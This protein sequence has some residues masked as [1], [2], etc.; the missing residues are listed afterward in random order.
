V[1]TLQAATEAVAT[2]GAVRI[3][4]LGELQVRRAGR[5]VALPASKRTRA[6]LGYLVASGGA[7]SRHALCDLLWDGPDDPRAELRWC[8]SKLRPVLDEPA[9]TRIVADRERVAFV[10][11]GA[12]TDLGELG[13]LL[14]AGLPAAPVPVLENAATLLAGEFLDG[15]ELPTCYRYN[16]WCMAERERHGALRV[17]VVAALV[18][19]LAEHPERALTYAR[20]LVAA[21]PS[22]ETAHAELVRILLALGRQR[23]AQLHCQQTEAMLRR[24]F[25]VVPTGALREAERRL[26]AASRPSSEPGLRAASPPGLARE[27]AAA[28]EATAT[29]V[30]RAAERRVIAAALAALAAPQPGSLLLFVGAPGIGKTRLLDALAEQARA[31]GCRVLQARCFEAEML[32]P[33]GGWIDALRGLPATQV[34]ETIRRDLGPLLEAAGGDPAGQGDRAGLFAASIALVSH[35]A[36]TQP[37]V[38]ILDD[39]QWVD[40]GSAALLHF[41]VRSATAAARVLV[42][43]AARAGEIDDNPWARRV[44]QSLSREQR[45][46]RC[47]LGPLDATEIAL[48]LAPTAPSAD[49]AAV[50]RRSGGNP[51][52]ALAVGNAGSGGADPTISWQT[53]VAEQVQRLDEPTRE[54]LIWAA[55]MGREF[56]LETLC[57]AMGV[58][59]T[60]LLMPL[61]RLERQGHLRPTTAGRYDFAHD[62]VR[63][64]V[65]RQVSQPRR[66]AIHRRIARILVGAAAAEPSLYGELAHHAS[67]ADD[68]V[69]TVQACLA[70]AEHC[71]RVFANPQALEAAERGLA[72]LP[73]LPTA[74]ERAI[75]QIA[76]LRLRIVAGIGSQSPRRPDVA[77][78]LQ[79][80]ITVAESMGLHAAAASGLHMLSWLAQQ[81]NDPARTRAAT[82]R[83]E[84]M[85]RTAD[86]A[87]RCQQLANSGR[88]LLEVEADIQQARA[89]VDAAAGM[90]EQLNLHVIELQWG[91]GLIARWDGDLAA[92][93]RC[94]RAAVDLARLREDR[95]REFECLVWL[96]TI[97]FEQGKLDSVEQLC[98]DVS[99]VAAR[100]GEI[101]VPISGAL[102]ALAAVMRRPAEPDAVA[103]AAL[104]DSLGALRAL[105]DKTRLAYVLNHL[106]ALELDAGRLDRAHAAAAEALAAAQALGRG[107]EIAIAQALLAGVAAA[108]G[109]GQEQ[110]AA[111]LPAP[112]PPPADAAAGATPHGARVK[113]F[114]RRAAPPR[115]RAAAAPG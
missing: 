82:L 70:T 81:A 114:L 23:D 60:D 26:R 13:T 84:R 19:R 103:L 66:R 107:S 73:R 108:R 33:Y 111:G 61:E 54:L 44:V 38:L 30:G 55:A 41:L 92:A 110:P 79:Q 91:R 113:A 8:L 105:D 109:P 39:L 20:V 93:Q 31:G 74:A 112:G 43:G 75:A 49:A 115:R 99:A 37:L 86:A 88:C 65:Y 80:A 45:V 69:L 11:H 7:H 48:L 36:A 47:A 1:E 100:M 2:E 89:L 18:E 10:A 21:D 5:A 85:S 96:A 58:A 40:E 94:L 16:Q 53:L 52:L 22:A 32:R 98:R 46:Q 68:A 63:E 77:D 87:T 102:R 29:L 34:P 97:E 101:N 57:A 25:G 35:L 64:A 27:P 95:W 9:A 90:A 72:M 71:L 17:K 24:D 15:L 50:H 28:G 56:Q 6:L 3:R 106:A 59:D 104:H 4:L 42:A 67:Q 76:L 14:G 78:A 83:A 51:L 62:L 12:T